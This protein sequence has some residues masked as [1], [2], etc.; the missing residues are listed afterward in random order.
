MF[1][2]VVAKNR[3]FANNIIFLQQFF[4][5]GGG[6][7][8]V[9][10]HGGAYAYICTR[11]HPDTYI[12]IST[13]KYMHADVGTISCAAGFTEDP[14]SH[15]CFWFSDSTATQAAA[16]TDCKSRTQNEGYVAEVR[17]SN[18]Y[19]FLVSHKQCITLVNLACIYAL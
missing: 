11:I 13:N 16:V 17:D 18:I 14:N 5:L 4:Q 2:K 12:Y 8:P 7:F 19:N 10:P 9:F 15:R 1:G 6:T 3:A